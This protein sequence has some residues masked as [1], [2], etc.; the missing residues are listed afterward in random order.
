M[1]PIH[2]ILADDHSI[3][4]SGLRQLLDS[5]EGLQVAG[6]AAHGEA[7]LALL[8]Q[9]PTDIVLLDLSM[10]GL[11]GVDLINRI[12]HSHPNLPILILSMH[13]EA[14][15]VARVLRAG[16][17][18]Y[19]TKDCDPQTLVTA[20]RRV[21]EGGRFIDPSLVDSV[22][23]Q[24]DRPDSAGGLPHETLSPRE[25]EVLER[26]ASGQALGQI[27]DDLHLSPKTVSTHK[28]RLMQKL[29]LQTNADLLKYAVRHGITSS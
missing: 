19:A 1:N 10:P 20:V 8:A 25:R 2:V 5:T 28:M 23:F 26:I 15:I 24:L 12:H 6:E 27:A 18:G 29:C 14:P 21:A 4:R 9:T 11:S 22:V 16:A 13:V 17:S 3:V 7:L